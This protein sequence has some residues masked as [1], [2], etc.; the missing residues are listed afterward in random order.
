MATTRKKTK[1]KPKRHKVK[2]RY[3][4]RG[5]RRL[6]HRSLKDYAWWKW[7]HDFDTILHELVKNP[8][9]VARDETATTIMPAK[10]LV[11]YAEQ[12]A[13]ALREMQERRRP[14]G[15]KPGWE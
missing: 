7:N 15:M 8:A 3:R 13:D 4:G 10:L 14:K 11:Q 5:R 2:L 6:F 9:I 1:T 12:F